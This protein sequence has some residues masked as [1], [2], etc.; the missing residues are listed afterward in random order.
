[1]EII[2][3]IIGGIIVLAVA[4]VLLKLVAALIG[5]ALI[6]GF[7]TWLIFDS[8]WA[9]AIIGGVITVILIINDPGEF[10][11]DAL[12]EIPTKSSSSRSSGG[13]EVYMKGSDGRKYECGEN[14]TTYAGG[15]ID[16]YGHKW[17]K[18]LDGSYKKIS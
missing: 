8:F 17:E 7:I 1:M 3:Y 9:G 2:L 4:I 10:F 14:P 16:N 6:L 18:Q 15:I 12:E 13:S 11:S 5:P